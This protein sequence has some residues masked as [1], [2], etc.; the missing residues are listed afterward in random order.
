LHHFELPVSGTIGYSFNAGSS[1]SPYVRGGLVYHYVDGDQY[2]GTSPGLLAAVGLEFT[3]FAVEL[4]TD[5]SEVELDALSCASPSACSLTKEKLNTYDFIA[6]F[7]YR[8]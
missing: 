2:S 3:H 6:S 5:R 8:F 4:A 1:M 7:Y